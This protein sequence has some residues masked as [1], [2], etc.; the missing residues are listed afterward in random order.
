MVFQARAPDSDSTGQRVRHLRGSAFPH[1]R[2]T[3]FPHLRGTAFPHLRGTA[4]RSR[5]PLKPSVLA[6]TAPKKS[7]RFG[8]TRN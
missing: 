4:F 2:G 6:A 3:A 5:I 8:S 7:H 1:L